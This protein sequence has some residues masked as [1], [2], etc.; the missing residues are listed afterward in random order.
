[1]IVDPDGGLRH[2]ERA[3]L[4]EQLDP[5]DLLVANDAATIPAS[6]AGIHRP[7]GAE[8]EIR[9]A[10][11]RTLAG[12]DVRDFTAIAFG[13][14]DHRTRTEDRP[15]APP[16]RIGDELELGPLAAT[17]SRVLV[18]ER[19]IALRFTGSADQIWSGIARHGKPIQYAHVP[20]PLAIWDVWTRVATRP[21]A[22]EPPSAGFLLD[23]KLLGE[24]EAREVGFAS[25]THAAGI[26]STGD[27][28]ID[29]RL[30]LD[31]A[32]HLPEATVRAIGRT[33]RRGGSVVALGTS[34][35]RA[36]EHAA[37]LVGGIRSGPGLANQRIDQHTRLR[38]VDSII[39]GV[40]EPGTGHY[41]L[42]RAFADDQ[43]LR[44]VTG[45]LERHGYRSHEFGDSVWLERRRSAARREEPSPAGGGLEAA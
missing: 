16:L 9:L 36:L 43:L 28:A 39:T 35:T 7:S 29:A 13:P 23:W 10:G 33:R 4:A 22:F 21:V 3:D 27:A 37:S 26:S 45:V 14:G 30:P 24:L 17:V 32:Y 34:V 15:V 19:L 38:V 6:L 41:H 11:R 25:L 8:I 20:D 12:D 40:H 5:G 42:L 44:R 18:P 2:I 1:L 31:E